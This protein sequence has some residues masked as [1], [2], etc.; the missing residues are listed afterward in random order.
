VEWSAVVLVI[1]F[2]VG[3][4]VGHAT[5]AWRRQSQSPELPAEQ[6]K[7]RLQLLFDSYGNESIDQFIQNLDVNVHTL[8]VHIA[9]GRQFR[10]Q[11][12]VEKAILVHQNLMAHPELSDAAAEPIIYE[13][14]KDYHKA[15]LYDRAES[16]LLELSRSRRFAE[17]SLQLLLAIYEQEKDWNKAVATVQRADSRRGDALSLRL[18]HY[19]CEQADEALAQGRRALALELYQ[20]ALAASRSCVRAELSLAAIDLEEGRFKAAFSAARHVASVSGYLPLVLPLFESCLGQDALSAKVLEH[21]ERLYQ[22]T[23]LPSLLMLIYRHHRGCGAAPDD[24]AQLETRLLEGLQIQTGALPLEFMLEQTRLGQGRLTS[25]LREAVLGFVHEL[26]R[27]QQRFR[28]QSCG[29]AGVQM[30][31]HCPGCH[32]WQ[33]VLPPPNL[34]PD[35]RAHEPGVDR[36]HV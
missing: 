4:L 12:E 6:L 17:K 9:V 30:Y 35:V 31:W 26:V 27:E 32:R 25:P 23:R 22:D 15:G 14:A 8:P 18:A 5:A 29:F 24:Q 7:H 16:L 19:H 11:G 21:L 13:L 34:L 1:V 10:Q 3:A 36:C 28:C 2:L 20:K 33:T